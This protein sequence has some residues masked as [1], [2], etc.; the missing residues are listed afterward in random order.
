MLNDLSLI[1]DEFDMK[2]PSL[3]TQQ[4][5]RKWRRCF[6][7]D[8]LRF[9]LF[10]GIFGTTVRPKIDG[11]GIDI[12]GPTHTWECLFCLREALGEHC[13]LILFLLLR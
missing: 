5:K 13:Y 11:G 3:E 12:P 10:I 1:L 8:F 7:D 6:F 2:A 9:S 4:W